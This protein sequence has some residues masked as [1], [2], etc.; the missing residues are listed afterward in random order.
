[1]REIAELSAAIQEL[2]L[3]QQDRNEGP[4]SVSIYSC[5]VA[6]EEMGC[7]QR[8]DWMPTS[9]KAVLNRIK[10][11]DS[12]RLQLCRELPQLASEVGLADGDI[13]I[14]E[15]LCDLISNPQSE[16]SIGLGRKLLEAGP[17]DQ[18]IGLAPQRRATIQMSVA[19][20]KEDQR[21]KLEQ[22]IAATKEAAEKARAA[23]QE[24]IKQHGNPLARS[25][26][27]SVELR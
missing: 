21:Q 3:K 2:E 17:I 16:P 19:S 8:T 26:A 22:G 4:Q 20:W 13:E 25:S 15:V 27:E 23:D 18:L 1:M 9:K 14:P 24:R 10:E 11:A 6:I 7:R 12:L 5:V